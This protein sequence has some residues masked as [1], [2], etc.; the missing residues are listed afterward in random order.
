MEGID[1]PHPSLIDRLLATDLS[2]MASADAERLRQTV[3]RCRA[4]LSSLNE[5][6]REARPALVRISND[7]VAGEGG[8]L[9]CRTAAE[10]A[11]WATAVAD[12]A[13]LHE[14]AAGTPP[15]P[16]DDDFRRIIGLWSGLRG[17]ERR[18]V[19][20]FTK[21]LQA[22][23]K[24]LASHTM[25]RRDGRS[26]AGRTGRVAPHRLV[27]TCNPLKPAVGR[28]VSIPLPTERV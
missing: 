11:L 22:D 3:L 15:V 14:R 21:Q 2:T 24:L 18:R 4:R 19:V 25:W 12:L 1:V 20:E 17:K 23:H 8:L 7:G 27:T 28:R 10:Y 26:R 5:V 9:L 13:A 16:G 6:L